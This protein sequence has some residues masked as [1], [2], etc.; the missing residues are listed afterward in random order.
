MNQADQGLRDTKSTLQ[1]IPKRRHH[2][3]LLRCVAL[4]GT[5][6]N[7]TEV[8]VIVYVPPVIESFFVRRIPIG[9]RGVNAI[10]TCTSD[11]RPPCS[12][13]W[14]CNDTKVTND[15]RHQIYH[16]LQQE[17]TSMSSI[18]IISH[19]SAEDDGNYTCLTET[20]LGNDSSTITF[21]YSD[22]S[23]IIRGDSY[24]SLKT[25]TIT[26]SVNNQGKRLLCVALHPELPDIRHCAV[27]LNVQG[28]PD[29]VKMTALDDLHDGIETNVSCR[30]FNGYPASLIH[31][32]IGT[33][34]VT[35]IPTLLSITNGRTEN[36]YK[37]GKSVSITY[38]RTLNLTCSVQGAR[39]PAE[40]E[41]QVPEE[42]Q[43]RLGG[44]FNAVHSDA[45]VSQRV[46]S[47]T[48]SRD[49]GNK[50]FRCVASHRELDNGLQLFIRLDVQV[51]P[52][53]LLLTAYGSITNNAK[54]SRSVNVF[55]C[56]ATSFTC[57]SIGS[58]PTALISWILA[59]DD[60]LGSTTSTSTT[61]KAD[62]GLR[63][64]NSTLQ[65]IP[66]RI[67][68][69]QLLIC[70]AS[71]G[72]NQRQAEVRVIVYGPPDPPQLN[73]TEGLQGGVSSNVTCTSNNGYPAPT[74]H[75]YLRS[76]NVTKGSDTQTL[77]NRNH[78]I[79]ATSIFNFTPTIDDHG[80]LLVCQVFQP[81]ATSM[82]S[83]RIS[84]VLNVLYSPVI[85][86]YSVRR[87][88]SGQHSVDAILTCTSDSRPLAS[89]TWF[90]NDRELINGT[91]HH[92]YHSQAQEDTLKS[93]ILNIVNISAE[94][95]GN[96][97]CLAETRLWK[98][99]ATI[100]F[101]YS[102]KPSIITPR[103]IDVK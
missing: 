87:F 23:D 2:T 8:R 72:M 92:I 32:Y 94:D 82:K 79:D 46:V 69:N 63:D 30:A 26:P 42:V 44:Q 24:I 25:A 58:S 29:D 15:T 80:E 84:A 45:Y 52:S 11:G 54:E 39:P 76:K 101:L 43:V 103:R 71:A 49:D 56:S 33:R 59:S 93:S 16:S 91:R 97:T 37:N 20:R 22:Q 4:A 60:D 75:W 12:I 102:G 77:R 27:Y 66:K 88:S 10:F 95:D 19:I 96:Y 31:W 48:P 68:H 61:N 21:S 1:L 83:R 64:T 78:R 53:N 85:V 81:N 41:W 89:I 51:P 36:G 90:L 5:N 38:G 40:L 13:A 50:I 14:L 74:F 47:V 62:Q 65:L 70:V 67:H 98:D 86:D 73:G 55:E 7:Q 34:N 35:P 18:L 28:P 9:Q 99:S 100:T 3:Q 17:D 6:Q 57:K